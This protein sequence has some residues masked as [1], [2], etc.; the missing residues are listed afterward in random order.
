MTEL[1]NSD[2]RRGG[3]GGGVSVG[4]SPEVS[5][6]VPPVVI[7]VKKRWVCSAPRWAPIVKGEFG[8]G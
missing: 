1:M 3:G 5:G 7:S 8:L 4:S 2:E 6:F